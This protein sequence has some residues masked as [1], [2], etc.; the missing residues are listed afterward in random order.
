MQVSFEP[1]LLALSINPNNASYPVLHSGGS[2][3]VNVLKQGQLELV[4]RFG[5]QSGR[6]HDKLAGLRWSPGR[7]GA[8][9][10]EQALAYFDCELRDT[11]RGGDHELVVG[12]VIDGRIL[13]PGAVPMAYADTGDIDG[14]SMLYPAKF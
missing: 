6:D 7:H 9:I 14:S 13:A 12:R 3:T 2:F 8:P 4:R 5:T 10:L 11:L 1:L